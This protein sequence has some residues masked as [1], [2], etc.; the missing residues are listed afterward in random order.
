MIDISPELSGNSKERSVSLGSGQPALV[1]LSR[2]GLRLDH[3]LAQCL[4]GEVSFSVN[5]K[6]PAQHLS[7]LPFSQRFS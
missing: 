7:T 2:L 1:L 4:K 5:D 3:G 6:V